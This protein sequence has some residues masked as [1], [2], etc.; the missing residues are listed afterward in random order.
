MTTVDVEDVQLAAE[1]LLGLADDLGG[2]GFATNIVRTNAGTRL[3]VI[4][5]EANRL[6]EDVYVA[7]AGDGTWWFW[8]S[9]AER[10]T[11]AEQMAE[12]AAKIAHVLATPHD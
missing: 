5:R 8:W 1:R 7:P 11:S 12:A 2:R 6:T 9:W 4:S 3:R 10:I